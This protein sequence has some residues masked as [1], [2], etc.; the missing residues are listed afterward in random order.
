MNYDAINRNAS[1]LNGKVCGVRTATIS[2]RRR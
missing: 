2:K 1:R